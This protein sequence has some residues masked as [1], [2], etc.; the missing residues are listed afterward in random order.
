MI[1]DSYDMSDFNY[2]PYFLEEQILKL[3]FM[4]IF[5]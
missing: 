3:G 1:D 4:M 2:K 5:L